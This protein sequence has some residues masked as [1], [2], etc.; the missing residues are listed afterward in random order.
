MGSKRVVEKI[1]AMVLGYIERLQEKN[2]Q[3]T[4][5]PEERSRWLVCSVCDYSAQRMKTACSLYSNPLKMIR[6]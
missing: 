5:S 4:A 6:D 3:K 1:L 2:I